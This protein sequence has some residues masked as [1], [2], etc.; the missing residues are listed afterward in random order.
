MQIECVALK[1]MYIMYI[2]CS[3]SHVHLAE[4]TLQIIWMIAVFGI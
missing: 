2:G 4:F 3:S 1:A